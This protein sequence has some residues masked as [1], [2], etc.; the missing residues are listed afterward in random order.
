MRSYPLIGVGGAGAPPLTMTGIAVLALGT[1]PLF[2][3]GTGLYRYGMDGAS[4]SLAGAAVASR[5]LPAGQGADLPHASREAFTTSLNVTGAI[6]AVIFAALAVLVLAMRQAPR[7]PSAVLP[8][9]E[10]TGS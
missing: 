2:A 8:D 9:H 10:V 3:L 6:A 7:M 1:G 5:D 4:D